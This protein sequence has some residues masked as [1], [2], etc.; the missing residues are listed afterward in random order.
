MQT[1]FELKEKSIPKELL[2]NFQS[3]LKEIIKTLEEDLENKTLIDNL[4]LNEVTLKSDHLKNKESPE[5]Y[6]RTKI[7]DK[8]L[9]FLGYS[10]KEIH[11][12]TNIP[13]G[14]TRREA[15]YKIIIDA[16]PILVEAEPLNKNLT[17][18]Y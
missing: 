10:E 9:R 18:Q 3:L 2:S 17:F 16:I 5:N 13:T 4:L 14:Q 15:D 8:I 12:A 11:R 7:I 1:Y 6:T